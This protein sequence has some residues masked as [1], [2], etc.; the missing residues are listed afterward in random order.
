[1]SD[2][3][4]TLAYILSEKKHGMV[5][6]SPFGGIASHSPSFASSQSRIHPLMVHEGSRTRMTSRR[7][8]RCPLLAAGQSPIVRAGDGHNAA[9]GRVSDGRSN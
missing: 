4:C 2:A 7:P 8:D 6:W 1:M 5:L 9:N 3:K